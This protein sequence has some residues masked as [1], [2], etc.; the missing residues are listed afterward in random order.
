MTGP[1]NIPWIPLAGLA[2]LGALIAFVWSGLVATRPFVVE[3]S[4]GEYPYA[5]AARNLDSPRPVEPV[6]P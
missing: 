6:I 2:V 5:A 4:A 1:R 3:S